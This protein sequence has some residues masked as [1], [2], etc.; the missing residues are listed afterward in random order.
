MRDAIHRREIDLFITNKV[1]ELR[2][3]KGISQEA[4]A[5]H[6]GITPGYVGQIESPKFRAKYNIY[7][8]NSIAK[9]LNCS[10]RDFLPEFPL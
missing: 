8:L 2:E 7:H 10:P 5:D 6:L 9:L 1:R 4:L 3:A